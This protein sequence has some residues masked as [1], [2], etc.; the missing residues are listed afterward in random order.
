ASGHLR[1]GWNREC[2]RGATR[3]YTEAWVSRADR[4]VERRQIVQ[5][6]GTALGRVP[7]DNDCVRVK[8]ETFEPHAVWDRVA[9]EVHRL[10]GAEGSVLPVTRGR[11][12]AVGVRG[13]RWVVRA[14]IQVSRRVRVRKG[15]R[16]R[17]G[18]RS[19]RGHG[20][21]RNKRCRK[22]EVVRELTL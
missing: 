8:T 4:S 7:L 2:V 3:A 20:V 9:L 1:V 11:A 14:L 6:M 10:A 12:A 19:G 21:A 17:T 15:G 13:R 5:R 18:H 22:C 16:G